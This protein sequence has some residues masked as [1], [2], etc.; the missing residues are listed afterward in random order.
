MVWLQFAIACFSR[1]FN[2]NLQFLWGSGAPSDT[3]FLW[4]TQAHQSDEWHPNLSNDLSKKHECYRRQTDRCHEEIVRDSYRQNRNCA[5]HLCRSLTASQYCFNNWVLWCYLKKKVDNI[6]F[7]PSLILSA[8]NSMTFLPR[9]EIPGHFQIFGANGYPLMKYTAKSSEA[10][11]YR[12]DT[13]CRVETRVRTILILGWIGGGIFFWLWNP[14]PG[15]RRD[16][17]SR[18][19]PLAAV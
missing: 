7:S 15:T 19:P 3:M 2:P 5:N 18:R 1:R 11:S 4:T 9:W 13:L 16:I 12:L 6:N 17:C 8:S 14:I 10:S